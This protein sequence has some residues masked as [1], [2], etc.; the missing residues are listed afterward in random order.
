MNEIKEVYLIHAGLTPGAETGLRNIGKR[1]SSEVLKDSD[2]QKIEL[3]SLKE[4]IN[5][6]EGSKNFKPLR[7]I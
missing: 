4:N 1:K 7:R 6:K 3:V 5:F 2:N